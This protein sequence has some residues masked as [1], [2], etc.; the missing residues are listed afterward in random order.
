MCG[1]V[2]ACGGNVVGTWTASDV[3]ISG[4]S[5]TVM[6]GTCS[7]TVVA[8]PHVSGTATFNG[9]G[10]FTATTAIAIDETIAIPAACLTQ[11]GVTIPC[12]LFGQLISEAEGDAGTGAACSSATGGGCTCLITS[13]NQPTT[14]TGT[15]ATSGDSITTT[16]STG[17]SGL[18]STS[19]YCVNGSHLHLIS[20]STTTGAD[21]G[22]TPAT[23][24]VVLS[25]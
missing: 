15:Y 23:V 10:T 14:S 19:T 17:T 13:Q 22:P 16:D 9:D 5:T 3:C 24:D 20:T 2:P 21:G 12:S 7:A 18:P 1:S 11:S 6:M 4:A 8:M 25:K